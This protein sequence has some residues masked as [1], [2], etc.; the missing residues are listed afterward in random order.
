MIYHTIIRKAKQKGLSERHLFLIVA[1]VFV[2]SIGA[3]ILTKK[4]IPTLP[5]PLE[6]QAWI[7]MICAQDDGLPLR[8]PH[9]TGETWG[10]D[11]GISYGRR[12]HEDYHTS[13]W[14]AAGG[15]PWRGIMFEPRHFGKETLEHSTSC[16]AENA[17]Q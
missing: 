5:K 2:V 12:I 10:D 14:R 11:R 4:D 3:T 9:R 13:T 6:K 16:G 17:A 7:D 1:A 8:I 15:S